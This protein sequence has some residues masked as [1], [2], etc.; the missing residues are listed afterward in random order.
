MWTMSN[1]PAFTMRDKEV[2]CCNDPTVLMN[3]PAYNQLV[4][5]MDGLNA[6]RFERIMIKLKDE[7]DS[8]Q[9]K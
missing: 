6:T 8:K 9:V 3:L 7:L 4:G 5:N 1:V 2:R